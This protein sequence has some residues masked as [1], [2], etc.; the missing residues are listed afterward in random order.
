[1]VNPQVPKVVLLS[2][3]DNQLVRYTSALQQLEDANI[4]THAIVG[5]FAVMLR[6]ASAHRVTEDLDT[7]AWTP[8]GTSD[9]PIRIL[10]QHGATRS[11]NGVDLGDT[12]IDLIAVSDYDP[13][14]LPDDPKEAM[15]VVS[16]SFAL[17]TAT[18]INIETLDTLRNVAARATAQVAGCAALVAMKLG[19]V[20]QRRGTSL[21]KRS[22]DAFDIYRLL[23]EHDRNSEVAT[24]LASAPDGL[25]PWCAHH[26]REIFDTNAEQ[27]K[28]WLNNGSPD[29]AS[30]TTD[31]LRTVGTLFADALDDQADRGS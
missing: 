8:D 28:R 21:H 9:A 25:A 14:Q 23:A 15:F 16:H 7:V 29:M 4:G 12:H 18:S 17:A 5:G 24:T 13:E 26:A 20:N 31:Q 22:S 3:P 27:T 10:M 30:I 19:A 1:M 2:G 6:L 11:R